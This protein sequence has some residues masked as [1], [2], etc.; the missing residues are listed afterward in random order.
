MVNTPPSLPDPLPPIRPPLCSLWALFPLLPVLSPSS[1]SCLS[2]HLGICKARFIL[3]RFP[4]PYICAFELVCKLLLLFFFLGFMGKTLKISWCTG[5][6]TL[7]KG[8]KYLQRLKVIGI[9]QPSSHL[10]SDYHLQQSQRRA[11]QESIIAAWP[12]A[13][14]LFLLVN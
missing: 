2:A 1:Y 11:N 10:H 4:L 3:L 14:F 7:N 12:T 6:K 5:Q 13:S 8:L 9:L